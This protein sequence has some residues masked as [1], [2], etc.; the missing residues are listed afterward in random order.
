MKI[1][2]ALVIPLLFTINV[3]AAVQCDGTIEQVYKWHNMERISILLSSTNRW[4][5]MP[6]K[7]D[8]A[9]ALMAFASNK[10]I[11]L[12]WGAED[13]TSCTDGWANNRSLEGYFL[14]LK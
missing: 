5:N 14:V 12:Y 9:M 1:I 10:S 8:E 13:I 3:N 11:R 2:S 7:S 6:T 4:V